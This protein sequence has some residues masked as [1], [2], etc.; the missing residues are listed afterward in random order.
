VY[1]IH[2]LKSTKVLKKKFFLQNSSARDW[3]KA[4]RR[5]TT[6]Q[7]VSGTKN[8]IVSEFA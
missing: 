4:Y 3:P 1:I 8:Q 6:R 5:S 2:S 7:R